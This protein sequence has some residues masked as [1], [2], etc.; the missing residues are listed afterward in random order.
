MKCSR[1]GCIR[2][3]T[4]Q[5]L[6]HAHYEYARR[7]GLISKVHE[8][9]GMRYSPEYRAWCGMYKRCTLKTYENFDRYGGRGIS[10]CPEWKSFS[11]FF[12]HVGKKPSPQHQLDRINNDGNYEPGT[13]RWSTP[14]DNSRNKSNSKLTARSAQIIKDSLEPASSLARRFEM[15]ADYVR[16]IKR[17][18][19]WIDITP[20]GQGCFCW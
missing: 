1:Q 15:S 4:A 12:A 2:E 10:V 17:G 11:A 8:T 7:K 5:G 6:C 13:V 20:S 16:E 3:S 19:A 18:S 14:S 9:H